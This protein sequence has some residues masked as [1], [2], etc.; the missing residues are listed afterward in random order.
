MYNALKAWPRGKLFFRKLL[1][2]ALMPNTKII[3]AFNRLVQ[4]ADEDIRIY[5]AGIID[6]YRR[7]WLLRMKPANFSVYGHSHRTNN[8]LEAYHR[9]LGRIMM[10]EHSDIWNFTGK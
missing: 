7:F 9:I 8:A 10:K 3:T 1:A 2:L 4:S 6:Y 5:F